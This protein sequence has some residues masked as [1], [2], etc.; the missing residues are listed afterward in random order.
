MDLEE[1]GIGL[2]YFSVFYIAYFIL[3]MLQHIFTVALWKMLLQ[4]P[5]GCLNIVY[6]VQGEYVCYLPCVHVFVLCPYVP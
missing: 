5:K 1:M 2:P 4:Q 6:F 3:R